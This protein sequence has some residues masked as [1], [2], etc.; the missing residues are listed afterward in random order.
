MERQRAD[1]EAQEALH[2]DQDIR[3]EA[4][5][6]HHD[7]SLQQRLGDMSVSPGQ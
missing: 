3:A 1:P 6:A 4:V 7:Q 2:H 5:E